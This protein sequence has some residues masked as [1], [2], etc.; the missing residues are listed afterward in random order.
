MKDEFDKFMQSCINL[1]NEMS[2]A[3]YGYSL[4]KLYLHNVPMKLRFISIESVHDFYRKHA[5]AK[6]IRYLS[7]RYYNEFQNSSKEKYDELKLHVASSILREA[8]RK[9]FILRQM[10]IPYTSIWKLKK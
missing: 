2:M 1:A 6:S 7:N 5:L 8:K 3:E 4:D 9:S 10:L